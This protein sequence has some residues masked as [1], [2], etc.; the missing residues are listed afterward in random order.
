MLH[1]EP[2]Y[3]EAQAHVYDEDAAEHVPPLRQ[4]SGEHGSEIIHIM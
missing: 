4:G 3:P 1:V 2:V